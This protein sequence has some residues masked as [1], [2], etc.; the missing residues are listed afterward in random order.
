MK[1]LLSIE[2]DERN[3]LPIVRTM[4]KG[5]YADVIDFNPPTISSVIDVAIRNKCDAIVTSNPALITKLAERI[6]DPKPSISNYEGSIFHEGEIE[7]LVVPALRKLHTVSYG[8][9]LMMRYL[10]K[11][12]MKDAWFKQTAFTYEVVKTIDDCGRMLDELSSAWMIVSDTETQYNNHEKIAKLPDAEYYIRKFGDK[13]RLPIIQDHGFTGIFWDDAAQEFITRTYVFNLHDGKQADDDPIFLTKLEVLRAVHEDLPQGKVFQNG[14]Y[15]VNV[16]N[17]HGM[18]VTNYAHDTINIFHSMYC[19][20]P[21]DLA[22][23]LAFSIRDMC[24][25][26]WM[27]AVPDEETQ[28]YYNAIDTWG[29]AN[30]FLSLLGEMEDYAVTNYVDCEFPDVFPALLC[31]M[32]GVPVDLGV[33]RA[34]K[35]EREE[36][37]VLLQE[38]LEMM[39]GTPG[40]NANSPVQVKK[41][42][43]AYG[44]VNVSSS[45]EKTIESLKYKDELLGVI[46]NKI[47]DIRGI[48]KEISSYLDESKIIFGRMFFS[49]N[50]HGTDT[51]RM[52]A[53]EHHFNVGINFQT[54]PRGDADGE[55]AFKYGVKD[56]FVCPEG[57]YVAEVDY[58]Q[59]ESRD[60]AYISGDENLIHAVDCGKDF[61]SLNASAFFGKPYEEIY[62]DEKGKTLDKPLRNLAKRVNHGAN[63]NMGAFVMLQTMGEKRAA[64]A[65]KLLNLPAHYS[66]QDT[67]EHLLGTFSSTYRVVK[68]QWYTHIVNLVRTTAKLTNPLGWTRV[69]FGKPWE[70]K[71]DKNALVA[72]LPQSTNAK[73]LC[74]ASRKVFWELALKYP[75]NFM[76][77]A[78]IH[79]S[80]LAFYR[81]FHEG[82]PVEQDYWPKRIEACMNL[83]VPVTD[84]FGKTRILTVPAEAAYGETS[85]GAIKG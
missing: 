53:K 16:L 52:A 80:I 74:V 21:K 31:E 41:L 68:G 20:L 11:L 15:D 65:K 25:W 38:E 43:H 44:W 63:Y 69:C 3:Y 76:Y 62:S 78:Q 23:M 83:P 14:K 47:L 75:Q 33:L 5:N 30:A 77:V 49:M 40:F 54:I 24:Y 46:L 28:Q 56:I 81:P 8:K 51:G 84:C 42:I 79:D 29:T 9:F 26:K 60:T 27:S 55:L 64:E 35:K 67:C 36:K 72:Q 1:L 57:W 85:W 71:M 39:V 37:L 48:R 2:R 66:L 18:A 10:K 34:A 70:N 7:I 13:L 12:L 45:D 19:E 73:T 50:P 82:E 4:L 17:A 32:Q 61:H 58:S 22:S 59:A 6:G